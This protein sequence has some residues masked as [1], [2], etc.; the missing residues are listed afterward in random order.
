VTVGALLSMVVHSHLL[1]N[2]VIGFVTGHFIK[3]E[4]QKKKSNIFKGNLHL[5]I[6]IT[7]AYAGEAEIGED[8]ERNVELKSQSL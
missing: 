1:K 5:A 6:I 7:N 4:K 3:L 8:Q 2:E